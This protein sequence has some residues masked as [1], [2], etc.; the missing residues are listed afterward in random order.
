MAPSRFFVLPLCFFGVSVCAQ[1]KGVSTATPNEN[2]AL[3]KEVSSLDTAFFQLAND[4]ELEKISAYVDENLEFY[5]DKAGLDVGRQTFLT[6]LKNNTCHVM[7][8][9]LV[10]GS[11]E[12]YPIPGY[13]AIEL[14]THRFHHPGHERAWPGAA[15]V[16]MTHFLEPG[17]EEWPVG[18]ARFL[19]VWRRDHGTWI[20]TRVISYGH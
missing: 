12:V 4:C 14:G 8:R 17:A 6:S 19:H 13:G 7:I 20:L 11:L 2:T 10:P 18:E 5:H 3:F 9:E 16:G 15:A 1:T